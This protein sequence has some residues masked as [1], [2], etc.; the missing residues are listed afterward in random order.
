MCTPSCSVHTLFGRKPREV[1]D[2]EWIVL[3][4][5]DF[6]INLWQ[7]GKITIPYGEEKRWVGS[8]LWEML[9]YKNAAQLCQPNCWHSM[10]EEMFLH[11]SFWN[12]HYFLALATTFVHFNF[13]FT[14]VFEIACLRV[15]GCLATVCRWSWCASDT[16]NNIERKNS[17]YQM[18]NSR[19]H[20]N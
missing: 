20:N 10:V 4:R 14:K 13:W 8:S 15:G 18:P 12:L 6:S 5:M 17:G 19:R 16:T 9:W 1:I 7:D 3:V 2:F 11:F